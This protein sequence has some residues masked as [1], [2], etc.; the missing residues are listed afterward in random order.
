MLLADIHTPVY[1]LP[2]IISLF[3]YA[4]DINPDGTCTSKTVILLTLT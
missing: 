3:I 2:V 4:G 1:L